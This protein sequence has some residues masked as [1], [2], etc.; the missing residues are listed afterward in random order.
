MVHNKKTYP[1]LKLLQRI[2]S[3]I[4]KM[5]DAFT[6]SSDSEYK[7]VGNELGK[8]L[9][10]MLANV[11]KDLNRE[12]QRQPMNQK[13]REMAAVQTGNYPPKNSDGKPAY[14]DKSHF[15]NRNKGPVFDKN[16]GN[17]YDKYKKPQNKQHNP[18]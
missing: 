16:K 6:N 3:D 13:N 14:G 10:D 2:A 15:D 4:V 9:D 12:K 17:N 5:I 18:F 1:L 11:Y 8:A 7:R